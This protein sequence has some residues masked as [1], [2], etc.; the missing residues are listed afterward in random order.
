MAALRFII[1][2][3]SCFVFGAGLLLFTLMFAGVVGCCCSLNSFAD[4]GFGFPMGF[5]VK[6]G[7]MQVCYEVCGRLL[8]CCSLC[9]QFVDDWVFALYLLVYLLVLLDL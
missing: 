7:F 4:F 5:S 8:F 2:V 9:I 3:F 6:F 1:S